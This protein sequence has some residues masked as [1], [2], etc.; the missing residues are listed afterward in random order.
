MVSLALIAA[1]AAAALVRLDAEDLA[2]EA[3][4]DV[5]PGFS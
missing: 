3:Q 2:N 4:T 5:S 1:Q